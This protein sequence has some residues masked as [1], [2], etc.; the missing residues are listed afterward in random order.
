ML[1]RDFNLTDPLHP[2]IHPSVHPSIHPAIWKARHKQALSKRDFKYGWQD[3]SENMGLWGI[4][5]Q[6]IEGG[7]EGV[8]DNWK[9]ARVFVATSTSGLAAST[10]PE[11]KEAIWKPFGEWVKKRREERA[12]V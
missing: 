8:E 2:S 5:S 7:G 11:E 1:A 10:K 4:R 6:G 12:A 3:E 9:G